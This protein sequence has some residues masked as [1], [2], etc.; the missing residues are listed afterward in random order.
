MPEPGTRA[1]TSLAEGMARRA[2]FLE[3]FAKHGDEAKALEK[4]GVTKW[5][6]QKWRR[7]WADFSAAHDALKQGVPGENRDTGFGVKIDGSFAEFRTHFLKRRSPWFHIQ[8]ANA[9]ESATPGSVTLFIWPPEHGKTSLFGDLATH[10]ICL[11]PTVRIT[12]GHERAEQAERIVNLV[13]QRLADGQRQY[14]AL[15]ERFG[16]FAPVNGLNGARQ[17]QTWRKD[18][19]NVFKRRLGEEIDYTMQALGF[20]SN[21]AGT[22]CDKLWIDD[23]QSRR[24]LN[25]TPKYMDFLRDDWFTRP[26]AHGTT[27]I[28]MN[29][30]GDGDIGETLVNEG[31]CDTVSILKA[32]D[33]EYLELG[34]RP[35]AEDPTKLEPSPWLWPERYSPE[36]YE[37]LKRKVGADGWARKYQ[38][39]WRPKTNRTFTQ[40]HLDLCKNP[41]RGR[42][43]CPAPPGGGAAKIS[44]S[45]DPAFKRT[46]I[47]VDAFEP[48]IMRHLDHRSARNL[49]SIGDMIDMVVEAAKV[50]H[51]P[52]DGMVVHQVVVETKGMQKGIITDDA[53][54]EAQRWFNFDVVEQVTGWDKREGELA[55][56][57][58]ARSMSRGEIDFPDRDPTDRDWMASLYSEL[59]RW[60]PE[61]HG[62]R[63]EQDELMALWFNWTRWHRQRVSTI[64]PVAPDAFRFQGA[65]ARPASTVQYSESSQFTFGRGRV[66]ILGRS[67]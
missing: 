24:S 15:R 50:W 27:F 16:P 34:P 59:L 55:V 53:L 45:L 65:P 18:T 66:P 44:I 30:V 29:V 28:A 7:H 22:R 48:T 36:D 67:R 9:I 8:A 20:N 63:L 26:G 41:L 51:R 54:V 58:M 46:A 12:V 60:R 49:R 43:E 37:T 23:P 52:D 5:A 32:Y 35:T 1:M 3:E 47:S 4:C 62:N 11:D 57:A 31:I 39:D 64:T 42:N 2:I 21:I 25:L 33:E 19:F 56:A 17:P 38:Q 14:S 10:A 40:E 13:R 6:L 61:L